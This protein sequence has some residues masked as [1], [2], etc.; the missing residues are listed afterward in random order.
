MIFLLLL[1]KGYRERRQRK[2]HFSTMNVTPREV[3]L[4]CGG[5]TWQQLAFQIIERNGFFCSFDMVHLQCPSPI[6]FVC[7][8]SI[9]WVVSL[10]SCNC[11]YRL[12]GP[13]SDSSGDV[14]T[15]A[16]LCLITVILVCYATLVLIPW[17]Y[18]KQMS[19]T[20]WA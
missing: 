14:H 9:Y 5:R 19:Q 1:F 3:I 15:A 2:K 8:F 4:I 7:C 16:F 17:G 20:R 12:Q 6:S 18:C 13:V 11:L 10:Y